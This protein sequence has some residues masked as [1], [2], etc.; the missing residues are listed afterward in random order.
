MFDCFV[1][2]VMFIV[3]VVSIVTI[4]PA[5]NQIWNTETLKH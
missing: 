1:V 4:V 3:P 5:D 2:V